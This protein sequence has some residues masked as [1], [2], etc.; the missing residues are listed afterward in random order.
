MYL[1]IKRTYHNIGTLTEGKFQLLH[2]D[3]LTNTLDRRQILEYLYIME[4]GASHP[5]AQAIVDA[6]RNEGVE[7][8]RDIFVKDH[9]FIPGEG[10][11]GTVG[12]SRIYVGNFRMFERL[13][14]LESLESSILERVHGWEESLGATIGFMSHAEH[15]I[16]CCYA[17]CDAVREEAMPVVKDLGNRNIVVAMLTGDNSEAAAAIGKQVGLVGEEI[18]SDL[19]PEE[20]LRL[21]SEMKDSS[22]SNRSALLNLFSSRSLVLMCGDGVNDGPALAAA[23]LSVAMGGG[24]ALALET[25]DITLLDSNLTKLI[26]SLDMG[27]RVI[28]KIVENV[29]FSISVKFLVLGFALAGKAHLFAAIASDVGAMILVTLNSMLLLPSRHKSAFTTSNGDSTGKLTTENSVNPAGSSSES[30]E[31]G[32]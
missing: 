8:P 22:S 23:D 7:K 15:G 16:L 30:E 9:S 3:M 26:Y 27:R 21:V 4:E 13:G 5:L 11:V 12:A 10:V 31:K 1:L 19:L 14:L 18:R 28:R 6:I 17:V 25:A 20:K 2:L 24:A 32:V 29:T